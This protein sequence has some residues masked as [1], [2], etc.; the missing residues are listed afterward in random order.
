L[1]YSF[2]HYGLHYG[3]GPTYVVDVIRVIRVKLSPGTVRST[4]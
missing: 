2:L 1:S 3:V 4:F